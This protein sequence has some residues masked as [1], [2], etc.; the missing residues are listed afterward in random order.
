[1]DSNVDA[2]FMIRKYATYVKNHWTKNQ[3]DCTHSDA[4]FM[5]IHDMG[6]TLHALLFFNIVFVKIEKTKNLFNAPIKSDD[7][8]RSDTTQYIVENRNCTLL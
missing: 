3:L 6:T 8:F 7:G 4:F 2:V 1:M 5:L